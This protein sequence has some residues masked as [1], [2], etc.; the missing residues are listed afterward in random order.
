MSVNVNVECIMQGAAES[1][2]AKF[3][4]AKL[5][6]KTCNEHRIIGGV[7]KHTFTVS[8]HKIKSTII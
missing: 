5:N 8:M 7:V 4:Y 3:P 6:G 1:I 2:D